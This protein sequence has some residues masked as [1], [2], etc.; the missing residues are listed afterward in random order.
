M[1]SGGGTWQD[2]YGR[3]WPARINPPPYAPFLCT[4]RNEGEHRHLCPGAVGFCH[5]CPHVPAVTPCAA[6][7]AVVEIEDAE[8]AN[9]VT[10]GFGCG[11][12]NCPPEP[13][14]AWRRIAAANRAVA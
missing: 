1:V 10:G 9:R 7:K 3:F 12:D 6:C 2:R 5:G 8:H 14:P 13:V 11:R 4:R